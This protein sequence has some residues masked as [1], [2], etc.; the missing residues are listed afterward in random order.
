MFVIS[1]LLW[2]LLSPAWGMLMDRMGRKPVVMIGLLFTLSWIGYL[3]LAHRNYTYLLPIIALAAGGTLA[4]AFWD[5]TNQIM[6]SPT[7]EH[8]RLS[9]VA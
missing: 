4:P 2:I 8:N 3:F 9:F 6:L 1:Q 5:G 7:P